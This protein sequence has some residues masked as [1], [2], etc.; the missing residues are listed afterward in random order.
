M[1]NR[2]ILKVTKFQLPPPKR[3]G[4]VIKNILRGHHAPRPMSNSWRL[5]WAYIIKLSRMTWHTQVFEVRLWACYTRLLTI[6]ILFPDVCTSLS[7]YFWI[8]FYSSYVLANYKLYQFS[9]GNPR[10][11]FQKLSRPTPWQ[12]L[13]L[14][15][16]GP[17]FS[18]TFD[19][20]G[21]LQ[22]KYPFL[23]YES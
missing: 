19:F 12:I 14:N 21:Q 23:S 7:S 6:F 4:T 15:P 8:I 10:A 1:L 18:G 20:E 13:W 17:G 9:Q 11:N 22:R 5:F 3:L 2:L 16:R